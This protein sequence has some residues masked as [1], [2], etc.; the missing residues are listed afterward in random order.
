VGSE[1][2]LVPLVIGVTG[3]RDLR[4][5][6]HEQLM[7]RVLDFF[8][9]L[10]SWCPSTPL[11]LLSPLAEGADRLVARVA[12]DEFPDS[13]RLVV[14]LP[15]PRTLYEAD[16]SSEASRLEFNKLLGRVEPGDC[17]ELPLLSVRADDVRLGGEARD[18][19]YA[20]AGAFVAR[21]SQILL[22][23]WDGKD[24]GRVGGTSQIVSFQRDGVPEPYAPVRGALELPESGAVHQIVTPR[25]S[26]G[27]QPDQRFA[28]CEYFPDLGIGQ[29]E[30][31]K[32]PKGG[33]GGGAEGGARGAERH[34]RAEK[35]FH[36]ILLHIDEFNR[37]ARRLGP[38]LARQGN[39][40]AA[41]PRLLN[42]VDRST[43]PVALAAAL[44]RYAER[45]AMADAM[46]NY[47]KGRTRI[48]FRRL[49]GLAF[50]AVVFF[51]L[52]AHL[53][54]HWPFLA[55][56]LAVLLGA[57]GWYL[58]AG[59]IPSPYAFL[60]D[61]FGSDRVQ[62][63]WARRGQHKRRYLDYRALAEG[64]QVQF[65][66]LLAEVPDSPADH[67]LQNQ[68]SELDWIRSAFRSW[69]AVEY[70]SRS[71][72]LEDGAG[73]A[74][75]LTGRLPTIMKRWVEQQHRYYD[76][77]TNRDGRALGRKKHRVTGLLLTGVLLA[78]LLILLPQ[79]LP[80]VEPAAWEQMP[81]QDL[82][83]IMASL[84]PALAAIFEGYAQKMAFSEE[85]KQ[86]ERM[87]AVFGLAARQLSTSPHQPEE[88]RR[89]LRELGQ[90][91]LAEHG[92]WVLL[93]RA[94]P[95][96]VPTGG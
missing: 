13:V 6:D 48:T 25:T 31:D 67:Y 12:L 4:E 27:D 44:D 36:R 39:S 19:Q 69:D 43:L 66:W 51:D 10:R 96:E 50:A 94:R 79:L 53:G 90:E 21:H 74:G 93:Q 65:F 37:D 23:L 52:Y 15:M 59:D 49:F 80:A 30:D 9:K 64:L 62:R 46:A 84:A 55:L 72:R 77:A 32:A 76:D 47:F 91:A 63:L 14:P 40:D 70:R 86:Y 41:A 17:F 81:L 83:I 34:G 1:P 24:T 56:Y 75:G 61:W 60:E 73:L 45:F 35:V 20:Q 95:V 54:K 33:H 28:V 89:M 58:W 57:Y 82:L 42:A 16:C 7:A 78:G 87:K 29:G 88:A 11:V 38:R 3:H 71:E 18:R 68:R 8:R 26:T 85:V 92:D 5:E 22:A 2:Y